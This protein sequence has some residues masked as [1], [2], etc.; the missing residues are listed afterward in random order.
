MDSKREKIMKRIATVLAS[1]AGVN[2]RVYRSDP[3]AASR[4]ESPCIV[5]SWQSDQPAGDPQVLSDRELTV[6]V[7]VITRGDAPDALADPII[8]SVHSLLMADPKLD[9]NAIDIIYGP[10]DFEFES[11]DQTAG[12]MT[13]QYRVLFRHSYH[14][15]TA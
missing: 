14:D 5:L 6:S 7:Q 9:N 12:R 13:Q 2:G 1:A 10:T 11:A 15:L 3:D 4:A 8:Q